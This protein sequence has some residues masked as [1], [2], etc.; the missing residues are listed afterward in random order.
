[1][2]TAAKL[3]QALGIFCN[4]PDSPT[5]REGTRLSLLALPDGRRVFH[6]LVDEQLH[7]VSSVARWFFLCQ[8]TNA[9]DFYYR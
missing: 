8:A 1:M 6:Y 4:L 7:V 2:A 9:N 3:E 5:S